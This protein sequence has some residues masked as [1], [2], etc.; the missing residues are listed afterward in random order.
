MVVG[1][2]ILSKEK[3]GCNEGKDSVEEGLRGEAEFGKLIN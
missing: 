3:G 1:W 2:L